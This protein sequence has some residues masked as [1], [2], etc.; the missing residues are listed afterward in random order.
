MRQM[1]T[2]AGSGADFKTGENMERDA[3]GGPGRSRGAAW[4]GEVSKHV[5]LVDF[6]R[7]TNR[8]VLRGRLPAKKMPCQMSFFTSM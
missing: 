7:V 4:A 2:R 3:T 6:N 8:D 5:G 1:E